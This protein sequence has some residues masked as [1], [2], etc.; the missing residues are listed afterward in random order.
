MVTIHISAL[1]RNGLNHDFYHAFAL[2]GGTSV[3]LLIL[4]VPLLMMQPDVEMPAQHTAVPIRK[5]GEQQ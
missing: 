1:D 5:R 4:A 3:L 2:H